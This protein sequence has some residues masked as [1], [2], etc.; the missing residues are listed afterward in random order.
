MFFHIACNF[1]YN[2]SNPTKN[3]SS[4]LHIIFRNVN[5]PTTQFG[6]SKQRTAHATSIFNSFHDGYTNPT[7]AY[8]LYAVVGFEQEWI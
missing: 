4:N 5:K 3:N 2:H 1:T 7:T 8:R 6:R